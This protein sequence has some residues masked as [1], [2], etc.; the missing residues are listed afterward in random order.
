MVSFSAFSEPE[1]GWNVN[2]LN[3]QRDRW[4]KTIVTN[5]YSLNLYFLI[6]REVVWLTWKNLEVLN[7][8]FTYSLSFVVIGN[9]VFMAANCSQVQYYSS[10]FNRIR[11][12]PFRILVKSSINWTNVVPW[13]KSKTQKVINTQFQEILFLFW[14]YLVMTFFAIN[15]CINQ[16]QMLNFQNARH[17]N[18]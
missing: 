2:L 9:L 5:I 1:S 4:T 17:T 13:A 11:S 10:I 8:F 14:I 16:E 15:H 3:F 6:Q 18:R 12:Y 7:I